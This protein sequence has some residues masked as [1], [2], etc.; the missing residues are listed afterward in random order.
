MHLVFRILTTIVNTIA[1]FMSTPLLAQ[2][3][4][5]LRPWLDSPQEW[6]RDTDAPVLS[7]GEPGEFGCMSGIARS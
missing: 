5:E 2:I 4:Q 1:V 6:S 3:P 7:I